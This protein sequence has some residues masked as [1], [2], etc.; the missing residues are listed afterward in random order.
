M[1]TVL[2]DSNKSLITPKKITIYQGENSMDTLR[3]VIPKS[4]NGKNITDYDVRMDYKLPGNIGRKELLKRKDEDYNDDYMCYSLPLNTQITK[5]AG[6]VKLSL[7]IYKVSLFENRKYQLHTGSL[8]I[9]IKPTDIVYEDIETDTDGKC[10]NEF[11][12][13]EF[14]I[15]QKDEE[16][17]EDFD[18]VEFSTKPQIPDEDFEVVEF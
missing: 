4:Y 14:S 6:D 13:V 12:V 2:M 10:D 11:D 1:Y 16:V 8:Y 17:D 18:V 5:Y 9:T 15:P 3:F 7:Y